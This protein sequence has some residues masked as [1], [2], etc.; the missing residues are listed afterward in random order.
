MVTRAV[1]CAASVER[2]LGSGQWFVV[3]FPSRGDRLFMAK[4]PPEEDRNVDMHDCLVI[5][6]SV[7]AGSSKW[8]QWLRFWPLRWG[9]V[10]R[11]AVFLRFEEIFC[12]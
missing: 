3:V 2:V 11:Y 12:M 1:A 5:L 10:T 4:A 8:L 6:L 7:T 9:G